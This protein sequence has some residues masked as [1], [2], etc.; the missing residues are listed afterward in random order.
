MSDDTTHAEKGGELVV[1]PPPSKSPPA[2]LARA[3]RARDLHRAGASTAAIASEIGI[4]ERTAR[5]YILQL[6]KASARRLEIDAAADVAADLRGI[7]DTIRRLDGAMLEIEQLGDPSHDDDDDAPERRV[8]N[9]PAELNTFASLTKA[10]LQA[11]QTKHQIL[12]DVGVRK[13]LGQ[14]LVD[15]ETLIDAGQMTHEQVLKA[16]HERVGLL[17]AMGNSKEQAPID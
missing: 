17:L 16:H 9:R 10:R 2:R 8:S 4:S 1:M 3:H 5:K 6:N 14:S 12:K 7:E 15:E 11:L 13:P